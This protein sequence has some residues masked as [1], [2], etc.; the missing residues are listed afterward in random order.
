MPRVKDPLVTGEYYHVYNRGTDKRAV[1]M[2][3]LDIRRFLKGMEMFNTQEPIY[4]IFR[5][6]RDEKSRGRTP[7][8]SSE[9][10]LVEF[11]AYCLNPNH[12]HFLLKQE[13]DGGISEFM[14]RMG[15]YTSYFN[16]R[17]KRTGSL[18]QGKFKHKL[19][20]SNE[21]LLHVSAYVNLNYKV[22]NVESDLH[23]SSWNEYVADRQY[24]GLCNN[25][26]ILEQFQSSKKYKMFAESSLQDMIRKKKEDKELRRVLL[27]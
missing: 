12:F 10:P 19:I 22:H 2:D 18:F 5:A 6:S 25:A 9:E 7:T 20:D 14:K 4:S 21:Y 1:F 26:I 15:G 24:S 3:H 17:H 8:E 11:V 23:A 27:E 13:T 16:N